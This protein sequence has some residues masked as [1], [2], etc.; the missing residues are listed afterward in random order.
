[1]RWTCCWS[2][3]QGGAASSLG[4][5]LLGLGQGQDG[6]QAE[7]DARDAEHAWQ[8]WREDEDRWDAVRIA[9]RGVNTRT[10]EIIDGATAG[11]TSSVTRWPSTRSACSR[12]RSTWAR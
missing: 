6:V 2:C 7:Q 4:D 8:A 3:L 1:M 12:A 9:R 5:L 10:G 11:R